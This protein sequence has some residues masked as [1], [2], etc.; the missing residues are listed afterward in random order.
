MSQYLRFIT[1]S[2][3]PIL[4]LPPSRGQSGVWQKAT[5]DEA[6]NM[7][8]IILADSQAM[9]RAGTA[10]LLAMDEDCRI[11]GQCA[12]LEPMLH[13]ITTFPGAIVLFAS[14]LQPD[15]DGCGQCW[16][17]RGAAPLSSQRTMRVPGLIC[18]RAFGGSYSATR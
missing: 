8:K 13:A 11:I 12:D 7:N 2:W 16:S 5:V 17:R 10:K 18:I 9:F 14:S 3:S 15:M 4:A 6:H 1:V